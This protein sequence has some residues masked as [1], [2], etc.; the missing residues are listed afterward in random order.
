MT[1]QTMLL[2]N[3]LKDISREVTEINSHKYRSALAGQL[4]GWRIEH[5]ASQ[6]ELARKLRINQSM[7]SKYENMQANLSGDV[8]AS[9]LGKLDIIIDE[10]TFRKNNVDMKT[11]PFSPI[12]PQKTVPQNLHWEKHVAVTATA[13]LLADKN[14]VSSI[15][16]K[17]SY[18]M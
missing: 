8:F 4:L 18:A 3:A 6:K 10:I 12:K 2:P 9:I 7:V 17:H 16:I 14:E 13:N 1:E 11:V 5:R 15:S